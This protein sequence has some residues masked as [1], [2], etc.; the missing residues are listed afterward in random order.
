VCIND[1][2]GMFGPK[3]ETAPMWVADTGSPSVT[4]FSG[5]PMCIPYSGNSEKCL[6][7]NR[8]TSQSFDALDPLC[9]VPLKS[10][11]FQ[12]TPVLK[13]AATKFWHRKPLALTSISRHP[14]EPT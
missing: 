9:M 7:S 13:L 4:Y 11:D 3:V 1:P 14:A 12:H 6:S 2:D 10:G 8:G 5:F